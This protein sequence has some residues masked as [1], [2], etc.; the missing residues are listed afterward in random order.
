MNKTWS[1]SFE[2]EKRWVKRSASILISAEN[3]WHE[4]IYQLAFKKKKK[5]KLNKWK[6]N[7]VLEDRIAKNKKIKK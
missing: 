3:L 6:T 1:K 5:K 4:G 2:S 7:D